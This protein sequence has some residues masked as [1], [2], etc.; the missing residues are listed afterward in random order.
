[1]SKFR[2]A[3]DNRTCVV[4]NSHEEPMLLFTTQHTVSGI[5]LE[6]QRQYVITKSSGQIIGV[7]FDGHMIYWTD[8]ALHTEKIVRVRK[9]GKDVETLLSSGLMKPEDLAI[10]HYTGNIYI[11]DSEYNH[12]AVCTNNGEY[13]K[14]LLNEDIHLPRSIVLYPQKARMYWSEWG[15]NPSIAVAYMDGTS[16]KTLISDRLGWVNGLALDW[17]NERLYWVDA[18]HRVIET[19][20]LDGTDRRKILS[21]LSKNPYSIAVF[22]NSIYWSDKKSKGIEYCDKFTGK[23][24]KILI[25]D[26]SVFGE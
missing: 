21:N 14:I 23:N 22:Q 17:P 2:L 10:D 18:R 13:C 24:R 6:S 26:R 5:D 20:R 1:M 19:S 4:V 25:K 15:E 7:S 12:I 3:A 9:N 8:I 16:A 11:S